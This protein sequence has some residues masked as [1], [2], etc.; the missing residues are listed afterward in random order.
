MKLIVCN[1]YSQ[2]IIAIQLKLTLFCDEEVD[3]WISDHS[4]NV[5][6]IIEPLKETELFGDVQYI[7]D[8]DFVYN[9]SKIG[10]VKDIIKFSFGEKS[11][12]NIK[13][14]QEIIFYSL[15]LLLYSISDYYDEINHEVK[16]SRME[17]GIFSYETDFET[18]KRVRII[19]LL[20]KISRRYE[21]ADHIKDYYCF[22]PELKVSHLEW[23]LIK[24]PSIK[25]NAKQMASIL[26]DIFRVEDILI[27]QKIIFFASS[28]DI[29]GK[30]YG[31]TEIILKLAELVGKDNL[32]VKVH[33]RD[34]RSVYGEYG[35]SVMENSWVPWEAMQL[36]GNYQDKIMCTVNSGAFITISALQGG[37]GKGIFLYP[38]VEKKDSYFINREK[39]IEIMLE[40]LHNCGL[41]LNIRKS[42][43]SDIE[44]Y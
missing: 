34:S 25:E 37:E 40:K 27:T 3:L 10:M 20:R 24:I 9:R 36:I 12:L 31:E 41:C 2:L 33:P 15:S 19:R 42:N 29:D 16:W 35:I 26:K 7:Q 8:K 28:S 5:D 21:I 6:R 39:D 23:N 44:M 13:K 38:V 32:L 1:T 17:E 22:F 43:Y 4:N 30:P 11:K 18:G 14:Y